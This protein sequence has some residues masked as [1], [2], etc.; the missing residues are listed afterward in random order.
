MQAGSAQISS[1]QTAPHP[2]L[3]A[4]LARRFMRPSDKPIHPRSAAAFDTIAE[5]QRRHGG[6]LILDAGCGTGMAT[7]QLA[8]RYPHALVFG[9]DKSGHRLARHQHNPAVGNYRLRQI[10]L[11]DFWRLAVRSGWRPAAHYLLYPNPWP[12]PKHLHRRWH[13]HPVFPW[14]LA[15]GGRIELRSNWAV[16]VAEFARAAC[17]AL[18]RPIGWERLDPA[19][20]LSLF[21]RKYQASGHHLYRCVVEISPMERLQWLHWTSRSG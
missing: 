10:D 15:L 5:Q 16:Y 2:A 9:V 4:L 8:A 19:E 11:V 1:H 18:E 12:K 17:L 13:A 3:P 7:Q 20:P 6:P 21:E 14:L